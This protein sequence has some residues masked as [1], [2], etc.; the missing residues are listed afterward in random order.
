MAGNYQLKEGVTIRCHKLGVDVS[1]A[2]ITDDI[3]KTLLE[4]KPHQRRNF[5]KLPSEAKP[6]KAPAPAKAEKPAAKAKAK[7][8]KK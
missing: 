3:A 5:T 2:N 6:A 4:E 8:E 1:N 7:D